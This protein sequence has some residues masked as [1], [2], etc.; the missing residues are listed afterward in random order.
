M[1]DPETRHYKHTLQHFEKH[2][3]YALLGMGNMFLMNA[4]D[5]PRNTDQEK[6][7]KTKQYAKAVEFFDKVL[8]LDSKVC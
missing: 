8:L 6:K 1:T 3:R 5:M 2:D 4:R 7:A